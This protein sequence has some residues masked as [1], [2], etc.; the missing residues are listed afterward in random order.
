MALL[1]DTNPKCA[2][3]D[4]L[5]IKRMCRLMLITHMF[6]LNKNIYSPLSKRIHIGQKT[7]GIM[8]IES[9]V[10]MPKQCDD[11]DHKNGQE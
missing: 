5:T 8:G 7:V 4:P 3:K 10:I 6:F 2:Q 1:A 11:C 9:E